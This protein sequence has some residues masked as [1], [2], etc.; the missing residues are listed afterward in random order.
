MQTLP[1]SSV[2]Y[3]CAFG[4]AVYYQRVHA[5]AYPGEGWKKLGLTALAF[6]GMLTGFFYLVYFGWMLA[7]WAPVIP[8]GM[9]ALATIPAILVER[10]VGRLA[11]GRL[12]LLAWPV[13]AYLMFNTLPG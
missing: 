12:S 9:S 3:Y 7:W 5:Q 6:L 13:C 11:L 2:A 10:L 4:I 1:W 8:L